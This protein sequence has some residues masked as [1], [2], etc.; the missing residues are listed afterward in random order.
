MK[1]IISTVI[2]VLLAA[3]IGETVIRILKRYHREDE[4]LTRE[5]FDAKS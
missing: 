1:I 3:L 5:E 4:F 2:E